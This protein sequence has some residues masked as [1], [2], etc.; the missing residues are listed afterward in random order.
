MNR[1]TDLNAALSFVTGRV[2]EQAVLSGEPLDVPQGLLLANLPVSTPAWWLA[3]PYA[4]EW[5][6]VPRD[7]NYDRL[8]VL[9]K[10]AYLRDRQKSP[11]SLDWEF[12]FAVFRLNRHPM[13]GLLQKAGLKYRRPPW[14]DIFVVIATLMF[15]V[16]G[17]VLVAFV[18]LDDK[19]WSRLEWRE[20]G[21]GCVVALVLIY[22]GA[23]R[24]DQTQ[25]K[26]E[27][28]RCRGRSHLLNATA[29]VAPN[30]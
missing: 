11:A 12:A 28:E 14:G 29:G 16:A 24:I 4:F 17:L 23:L 20:F 7:V 19:P 10:A 2:D 3:G 15:V 30:P 21:L 22:F 6:P 18:A 9:A 25:L 8:C 26:K 5:L 13:W 27:I 1:I